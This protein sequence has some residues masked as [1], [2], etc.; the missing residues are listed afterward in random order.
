MPKFKTLIYSIKNQNIFLINFF[1][2]ILLI[3]V[4][5][6][7]FPIKYFFYI[8]ITITF[9]ISYF[10]FKKS[11]ELSKSLIVTNL[12]IFFLF[13]FPYLE[14]FFKYFFG[15]ETSVY[16]RI[17]YNLFIVYLFVELS[18]NLNKLLIFNKISLRN[19]FKISL[20][21]LFLGIIFFVLR[22]P[23]PKNLY[24]GHITLSSILNFLFNTLSISILEEFMIIGI[25]YLTYRKVVKKYDA[26][27]QSGLIFILFHLIRFKNLT[28]YY[29]YN[30]QNIFLIFLILY[31]FALF[32]FIIISINLFEPTFKI[33]K[34]F[35]KN[36]ER[37]IIYP[38]ILHMLT[39][40]FL[41]LF[42][43]IFNLYFNL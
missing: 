17:F 33:F 25:F 42:T 12:F 32:I 30:F 6:F 43:N 9:I 39:D 36:K 21:G 15:A 7:N 16:I 11:K 19:I 5:F 1:L 27:Y 10:F 20:F 18:G 34:K 4:F 29:F 31:Y 3:L 38:V 23:L 22:E 26:I 37:N 41:V 13:L 2:M 14:D 24:V 28:I 8:D 35:I 40:F